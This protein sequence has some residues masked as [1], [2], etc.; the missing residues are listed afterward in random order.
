MKPVVKPIARKLA[1]IA[2]L[3]AGTIT[4]VTIPGFA[5]IPSDFCTQ[6]NNR[7]SGALMI[8]RTCIRSSSTAANA[9]C[10]STGTA[11]TTATVTY[12]EFIPE[13][14]ASTATQTIGGQEASV[15]TC[16]CE[17]LSS[18]ITGIITGIL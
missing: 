5:I 3:V 15:V 7:C 4:M 8:N 1:I 11:I 9:T 17:G 10:A 16:T 13:C 18:I 6:W 12:C 2:V 14:N